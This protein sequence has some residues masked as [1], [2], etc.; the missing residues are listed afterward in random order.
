MITD[1][2]ELAVVIE[3]SDDQYEITGYCLPSQ[4]VSFDMDEIRNIYLAQS[5]DNSVYKDMDRAVLSQYLDSIG[6]PVNKSSETEN[7]SAR[8]VYKY[9]PVALKTRPVMQEL[10][11]EFRIKREIIG[12]PLAE[13][14]KL[15]PNKSAGPTGCDEFK[16]DQAVR[17]ALHL[18]LLQVVDIDTSTEGIRSGNW[19]SHLPS[20]LQLATL[21][22]VW[23]GDKPLP[24]V[25][26]ISFGEYNELNTG[27]LED[28]VARFYIDSFFVFFGCAAVIPTCLP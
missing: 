1:Q 10:P 13:M 5:I 2:G 24:L 7:K 3:G 18:Q 16:Y 19:R 11:P 23:S 15:S 4:K 28:A 6:L 14:P 9:K 21:M 26:D 8:S 25:Q 20:L 17:S 12:D 22:R 27:V